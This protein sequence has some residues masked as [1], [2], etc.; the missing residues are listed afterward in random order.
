MDTK[1]KKKPET[2]R[3]E[4]GQT[5]ARKSPETAKKAPA[6]AKNAPARRT[7][8]QRNRTA[9]R[10]R[11]VQ[12]KPRRERPAPRIVYTPP[13]PFSRN[14]LLLRLATTV[15]VVLALTFGV[16]IFFKVSTITVSGTQKYTAWDVREASGIQEG[17]NLL[18]FG[19]ARAK[20]RIL[21]ELPYVKNVRMGIKLPDTVNI[22]IVEFEVVYSIRDQSG[23][24]WLMT[25][26]GKVIEQA[27]S[28]TAGQY[29]EVLGVTLSLP[30]AGEQGV[31]VDSAPAAANPAETS[32]PAS[33][34]GA[35]TTQ[36]APVTVLGSEQLAAALSI[37]QYLEANSMIGAVTS[38]DV[39]D[40]SQI[41]LWYG[42][43]YQV[44]LGDTSQ[45]N[46]K[47]SCLKEAVSKLEAYQTGEL[48]ISF[49]FWPDEVGYTPFE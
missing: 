3:R 18:T 33:E 31:A 44:K 9:E 36:A 13:K 6:A 45:M 22:E 4:S 12:A 15:A 26:D 24:W 32:D 19:K 37:L 30:K 10:K 5:A 2:R 17:E 7:A 21:A 40:L 29:T 28:A 27:D 48:D 43:Q 1:Q 11:R 14:R 46:Y 23:S 8:S 35:D 49:T 20:A 16:S 25:S 47:I 34:T 41:E 42:T 39:T 38:V